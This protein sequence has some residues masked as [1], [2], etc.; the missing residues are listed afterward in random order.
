MI[1]QSDNDKKDL[2]KLIAEIEIAFARL[3][4][5]LSIMGVLDSYNE[6]YDE[7]KELL[8]IIVEWGAKFEKQQ[9]LFF[10]NP[11][12]L[13]DVYNRLDNLKDQFLFN[14]NLGNENELSDEIVIWMWELML[15][16]KKQIEIDDKK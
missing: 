2:L 12:E 1:K 6:A 15:L 11:E 9:N 16:R 4:G 14:P 5:P 7:I 8:N 10:I 3:I 13:L